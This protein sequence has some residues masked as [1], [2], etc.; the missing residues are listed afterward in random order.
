MQTWI[1]TL[2]QP[3][4]TPS[5][6]EMPNLAYLRACPIVRFCHLYHLKKITPHTTYGYCLTWAAIQSREATGTLAKHGRVRVYNPALKFGCKPISCIQKTPEYKW[7]GENQHSPPANKNTTRWPPQ[8]HLNPPWS[9][10]GP[11]ADVGSRALQTVLQW[12]Q[13]YMNGRIQSGPHEVVSQV[14]KQFWTGLKA[15]TRRT[16]YR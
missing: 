4:P 9:P 7:C 5:Y 6:F 2:G 14:L 10:T 1:C 3:A 12:T 8:C 13:P 15:F 11:S 16:A